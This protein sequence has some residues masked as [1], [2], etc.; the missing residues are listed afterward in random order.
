MLRFTVAGAEDESV[1]E[2]PA[3]IGAIVKSRSWLYRIL[4]G[5]AASQ[6]DLAAQEGYDER[7]V[8]RL[9]PLA[10][11]ST[12]ITE[13]VIDGKQPEHRILDTLLGKLPLDWNQQRYLLAPAEL[14]SVRRSTL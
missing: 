12:E 14:K 3:L 6:R 5:E 7:Y 13:A 10:F 11:L 2:I 9:L 1:Q 8:S 4:R